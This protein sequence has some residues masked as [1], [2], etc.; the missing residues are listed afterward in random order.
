MQG[1][2]AC[3]RL[4][5]TVCGDCCIF[6]APQQQL[7]TYWVMLMLLSTA[8]SASGLLLWPSSTMV[9]QLSVALSELAILRV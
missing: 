7:A 4:L 5:N 3:E 6:W 1:S 9:M 8:C 2:T